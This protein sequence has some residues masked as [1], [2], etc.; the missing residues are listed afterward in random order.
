[1]HSNIYESVSAPEGYNAAQR[2]CRITTAS[3]W[4]FEQHKELS[5]IML[6]EAVGLNPNLEKKRIEVKN[7]SYLRMQNVLN[8]LQEKKLINIPDSKVGALVLE[9]ASLNICSY[10]LLNEIAESLRTVSYTMNIFMLQALGLK[11]EPNEVKQ[12]IAGVL[13]ELD[14]NRDQYI[15]L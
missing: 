6:I 11:F 3:L 10:W 7:Q 2:F 15:L 13:E 14:E 4:A 1:M 9:G 12:A 5:R 8:I